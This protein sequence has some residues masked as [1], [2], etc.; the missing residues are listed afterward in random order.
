MS[1]RP[2]G[3]RLDALLGILFAL[4][5]KAYPRSY[6]GID[7]AEMKEDFAEHLS[8]A[9]AGELGGVR[10]LCLR[11]L[12]DQAVG[13]P[14]AWIIVIARIA[15]VAAVP[16]RLA[17]GCGIAAIFAGATSMADGVMSWI[18]M[19]LFL[20]HPGIPSDAPLGLL[21]NRF[22][23]T[24]LIIMSIIGLCL[25]VGTRGSLARS[26]ITLAGVW[27]ALA[28]FLSVYDTV[29]EPVYYSNANFG[30]E[31]SQSVDQFAVAVLRLK[32]WSLALAILLLAGA[33]LVHRKLRLRWCVLLLVIS[34][35]QSSL[36]K[37][38]VFLFWI[39]SMEYSRGLVWQGSRESFELIL[40]LHDLREVLF[41]TMFILPGLSWML[42]GW[43]ILSRARKLNP[44]PFRDRAVVNVQQDRS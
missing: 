4:A 28:L 7:A 16:Q 43:L 9:R 31:G 20:Q 8:M 30:F 2:V 3:E 15:G 21:E 41:H 37:Q 42:L 6:R 36:L 26:G 10:G 32:T 40:I 1:H 17:M 13:V 39:R 23:N 18:S 27:A 35:A 34:F 29:V 22:L 12:C 38:S 44:E 19:A 5:I 14:R 11:T 33:A 24:L 25:I